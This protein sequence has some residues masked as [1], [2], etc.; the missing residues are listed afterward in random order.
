[1]KKKNNTATKCCNKP[2]HKP[3]RIPL[4]YSL[5][6]RV[7]INF[8]IGST[9]DE[10]K[11]DKLSEMDK[12]SKGLPVIAISIGEEH[13]NEITLSMISNIPVGI[14]GGSIMKVIKDKAIVHIH[15]DFGY[16]LRRYREEYQKFF[17]DTY[18]RSVLELNTKWSP[19]ILRGKY[20][21][22][23][24]QIQLKGKTVKDVSDKVNNIVTQLEETVLQKRKQ[25]Y[26]GKLLK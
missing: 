16:T 15:R 26:K 6:P 4:D 22:L 14:E 2:K 23:K 12:K 21:E 3:D 19:R 7:P 18:K 25:N 24:F 5:C 20:P 9:V 1:L 13:L 8:I 11:Y 10:N 17:F